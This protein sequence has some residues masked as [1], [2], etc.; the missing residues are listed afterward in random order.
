M[1]IGKNCTKD[2]PVKKKSK[3]ILCKINP[4][5][6]SREFF[7]KI[8][9]STSPI[10]LQGNSFIKFNRKKFT[11]DFLVKKYLVIICKMVPDQKHIEKNVKKRKRKEKKEIEKKEIS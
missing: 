8:F 1:K 5:Q 2:F 10:N 6:N 9:C 4:N 11:K 3:G 7:C